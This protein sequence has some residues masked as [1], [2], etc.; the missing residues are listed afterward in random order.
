MDIANYTI[1]PALADRL[2]HAPKLAGSEPLW[3]DH[4]Y[5]SL[6]GP[7][8]PD[9]AIISPRLA[10]IVAV[11]ASYR[12]EM[13]RGMIEDLSDID[14]VLID[15][16]PPV[17]IRY[18]QRA[19]DDAAADWLGRFLATLDTIAA[20]IRVG[21]I[22]IPRC[23]AEEMALHVALMCATDHIAE[24][25]EYDETY[26][27]LPDGGRN[28]TDIDQAADM[29]FEDHDVLM[30][31]DRG[32]DGIE[33]VD[34]DL[35]DT[36]GLTNLH[37]RDWFVAFRPNKPFTLGPIARDTGLDM[38]LGDDPT[39]ADIAAAGQRW[40][41][42][43]LGAGTVSDVAQCDADLWTV[44]VDAMPLT[45]EFEVQI[46][47]PDG[48]WLTNGLI[49]APHHSDPSMASGINVYDRG[50]VDRR[51]MAT[52]ARPAGSHTSTQPNAA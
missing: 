47:R 19:G 34:G 31:F 46:H 48:R 26:W 21:E 33:D 5:A 1:D 36:M 28:D 22:P 20:R 29:W 25:L 11:S 18:L 42:T 41:D 24:D 40:L 49:W 7:E 23:T 44:Y 15:D 51:W 27:S 6:Y 30:L 37:P 8:T 52:C 2:R 43:V 14:W 10:H 9:A 38:A 32:L 50:P 4:D 12:S 35:D 17:A 45:V 16:L 13:L 39:P 3:P